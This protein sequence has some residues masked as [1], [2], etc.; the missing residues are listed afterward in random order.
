MEHYR[1]PRKIK[2]S[3]KQTMWLYPPDEE[4]NCLMAFPA[5]SQED[6]I[7]IKKG[8]AKKFP[9]G[10]KAERKKLQKKLDKEIFIPDQ[11][12]KT[13]VEDIIREDLRLSS[14]TTLIEAKNSPKAIK[15]YFNFVNAY[16][17]YEEG[18]ESYGNICCIAIDSARK[19]L[20]RKPKKQKKRKI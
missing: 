14:Y 10:T 7:A 12:L 2:K 3:L 17:L 13:Y 1:L 9:E 15:A 11:V 5:R 18:E 20:K 8:I 6:Y 4:G 19:L 16:Q